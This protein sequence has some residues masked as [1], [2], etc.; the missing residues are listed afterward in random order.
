MAVG[1]T[2][3][4]ESLPAKPG[5]CCY[6]EWFHVLVRCLIPSFEYPVPLQASISTQSQCKGPQAARSLLVHDNGG[7]LR[8][9]LYGWL[10]CARKLDYR[11]RARWQ[12]SVCARKVV[13]PGWCT[14][15]VSS[16]T[17]VS[18]MAGLA[19]APRQ[20]RGGADSKCGGSSSSPQ[21]RAP[22][23]R[24]F[25]QQFVPMCQCCGQGC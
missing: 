23:A 13:V 11:R 5:A 2:K 21:A 1:K 16:G 20:G 10:R 4:G 8:R 6:Y 25:F 3:E 24:S 7:G 12:W 14:P 15:A 9:H 17:V 19:Q 18:G 22:L